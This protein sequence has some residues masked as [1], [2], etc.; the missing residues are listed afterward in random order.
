MIS[1][2][3]AAWRGSDRSGNGDLSSDSGVLANT[4]YSFTLDAKLV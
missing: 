2:A 1:K 4:P 3:R